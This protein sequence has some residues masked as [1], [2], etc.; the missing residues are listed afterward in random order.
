MLVLAPHP[1]DEVIGCG[2]AILRHVDQGDA[3][4]VVLVTDG[5]AAMP[6]GDTADRESYRT[7]RLAESRSAAKVLGYCELITWQVEDRQ[8]QGWP[9]L[10]S[11]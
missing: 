4:T 10:D 11:R 9:G 3:V 7:I 1:D 5:A 2:G 8:L 6:D